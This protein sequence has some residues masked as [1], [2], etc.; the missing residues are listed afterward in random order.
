MLFYAGPDQI[1]PL[2]GLLGTL[3]GM[4]LVFWSKIVIFYH[5]LAD[6]LWRKRNSTQEKSELQ[7]PTPK[8]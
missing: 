5:K 3:F 1:I 2:T 4:A 7:E 6:S 8:A